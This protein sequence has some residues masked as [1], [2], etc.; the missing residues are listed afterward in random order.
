M[1]TALAAELHSLITALAIAFGLALIIAAA[2]V[3]VLAD[4]VLNYRRS[5]GLR[6]VMCPQTHGPAL[7]EVSAVHS[8]AS[9]FLG[10]GELRIRQCSRWLASQNCAHECLKGSR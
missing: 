7:I 4:S 6:F 8:A 9:L 5:H 1:I 3:A 10:D 2:V